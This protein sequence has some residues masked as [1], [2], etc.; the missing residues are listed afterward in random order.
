MELIINYS[1]RIYE[2]TVGISC[3]AI[4][5]LLLKILILTNAIVDA[6]I[7]KR[8]YDY[9]KSND[10]LDRYSLTLLMQFDKNSTN[11]WYEEKFYLKKQV[12]GLNN[13]LLNGKVLNVA[14]C[15]TEDE[16]DCY[17]DDDGSRNPI[18][19]VF[20]TLGNILKFR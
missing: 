19:E 4:T 11:E 15:K 9:I 8:L 20:G 6:A 12:S 13:S 2:Q 7:P 1:L 14:I 18:N 16:N 3:P 10:R 17:F 5:M